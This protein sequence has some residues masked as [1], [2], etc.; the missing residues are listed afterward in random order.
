MV[1]PAFQSTYI[2]DD[3]K[4]V[5]RFSFFEDDSLILEASNTKGKLKKNIYGLRERDYSYWSAERLLMI[6]QKDVYS[7]EVDSLLNS[8]AVPPEE[9]AE[10]GVSLDSSQMAMDTIQL[11]VRDEDPF[12]NTKRFNYNV[13]FVNYM[14]LVGNDILKAQAQARDSAIAKQKDTAIETSNTAIDST[15]SKPKG[16]FFKNLFKKKDIAEKEQRRQ[17]RKDRK[18][19]RKKDKEMKE[20]NTEATAPDEVDATEPEENEE[21]N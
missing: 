7:D 21:E 11:E 6:D 13:D 4:Q 12:A 10:S 9:M 1:C 14:L 19:Q 5:N 20:Q 16:G 3:Q 18:E 8:S 17:D 2:L 15:G